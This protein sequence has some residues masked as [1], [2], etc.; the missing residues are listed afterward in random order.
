MITGLF[1]GQKDTSLGLKPLIIWKLHDRDD[2][3]F[4]RSVRHR[5]CDADILC[6]TKLNYNAFIYGD[7]LR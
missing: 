7:G 3:G 2:N 4:P 6:L 1:Y 5:H